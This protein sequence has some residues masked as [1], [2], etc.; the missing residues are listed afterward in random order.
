MFDTIPFEIGPGEPDGMKTRLALPCPATFADIVHSKA[1]GIN[2]PMG[3]NEAAMVL[4]SVL[5]VTHEGTQIQAVNATDEIAFSWKRCLCN[6]VNNKEIIP[7]ENSAVYAVR[8][9]DSA[10]PQTL[11][12]QV[13]FFSNRKRM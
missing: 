13:L 10:D 7:G 8:I 5:N 12:T 3:S 2:L 4:E 9:L 6:T 1:P 11:P